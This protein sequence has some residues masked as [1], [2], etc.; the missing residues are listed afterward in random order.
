MNR[1][2]RQK[3]A[4]MSRLN[5]ILAVLLVLQLVVAAVVLWPAPAASG[6]GESLLPGFQA[7]R[8]VGVTITSGTGQTV[9]L[10]RRDGQW[11]LASAGD[12]PVQEDKVPPFLEKIAKLQADR[13]VTETASSHERLGVADDAYERLVEFEMDDGTRYRLYIGTSPR[14]SATHVRAGGQDA[15]YLTSEL[16]AQDAGSEA[17]AWVDRTYLEI[18]NDQIVALTLENTNGRLEFVKEG[19][20]WTLVGLQAG[21]VLNESSVTTLVNRA[22]FTTLLEPLGTEEKAAYGMADPN[23]VV[24]IYTASDEGGERTYTLWVGAQDPEDNSYVVTSSESPYYVR[25]AEFAARDFVGK[26][27]EDFLQQPTPTPEAGA[28]PQGN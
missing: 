5:L 10:T 12:Y 17:T 13:P 22:A 11:V 19:E 25:V 8:V 26:A 6:E 3:E 2:W 1:R 4:T 21:D 23:A 9:Q 7:D 24:T 28:T 18:P 15:V 16:S 20:T 14:F 27:Y